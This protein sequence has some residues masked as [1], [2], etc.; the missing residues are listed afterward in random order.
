MQAEGSDCVCEF[1]Q[2]C[3][4]FDLHEGLENTVRIVQEVFCHGDGKKDCAR[5]TVCRELG[6]EDVPTGLLPF[7]H[8]LADTMI[9]EKQEVPA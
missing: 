8:L 5:Y 4:F 3:S 1:Y 6:K 2:D 7:Q 9:A